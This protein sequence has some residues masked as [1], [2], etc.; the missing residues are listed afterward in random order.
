MK[1]I[2]GAVYLTGAAGDTFDLSAW[3]KGD[4]VPSGAFDIRA[5]FIPV[6]GSPSWVSLHFN[7]DSGDW[8]YLNDV[9]KAPI[10]Y[11]RIDIY[12]AYENNANSAYYDGIQLYKEEFG[13]SY[14]YDAKGNLTSN[15]DIAKNNSAFAYDGS[16]NLIGS[17]DPKGNSFA[18]EYDG[19]HNI[20]K[21]TSSEN[22][23]YNFTYDSYGNSKTSTIGDAVTYI[24]SSANYT[25]D[26]NYISSMTDSSG[27][28]V[29]YNYDS[30]KGTLSN[31]T[32]AN[33]KATSYGYD[34]MNRLTTASKTT[35]G[36]TITNSYSYNNDRISTIT[37]N[38][39]NYNFGYDSLGNN[40]TVAVGTQNLITNNYEAKTGKLLDSTYGNGQKVSSLY[41]GN[42]N[43]VGKVYGG[44]NT[45][46]ISYSGNIQDVGMT[47]VSGNDALLGTVGQNKR[48]ESLA[49]NLSNIPAGM[50]IKY[51][52]H[53]QNIG[54]QSWVYDGAMA[55][56]TG[57][58]LRMEAVCIK[59]EG[60]PAGYTVQYQAHV[61]SIGW[62]DPVQDGQ[63]AGTMGQS[64]RIEAIKI[65]LVKQRA[66]YKFDANTNLGY[67][68]DYVNG[69]NYNYSY[70]LSN[71]LTR[72]DESN[73]N[74]LAYGYDQN[75]NMNSVTEK[76]NGN[77]YTTSYAFDKDNKPTTTTYNRATAN[78]LTQS[79]DA[80]GRLSG[81]AMNT[82]VATYNTTFGYLAG[83]N[84]STTTK[85][86]S[87][88]NNGSAISYTYD[89]NGNISTITN[90]N[91]VIT[92][93]Y[94]ELNEIVRE[95]NQ[96]LNKTITTRSRV[97]LN[98]MYYNQFLDGI[99]PAYNATVPYINSVMRGL[100]TV[101]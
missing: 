49:V 37:H 45:Q 20:K 80:L 4:S 78:T 2:G 36:Q 96:V 48:L 88:T 63:I 3:A 8:Q 64:L 77:S 30:T 72:I 55:G 54:W 85:V 66:S 53:V 97:A 47:T 7:R 94:N 35:D 31:V 98:G 14:S 1:G 75:S 58:G 90:N 43:V 82:G 56:T 67:K 65:T 38:G 29:N 21:A 69:I 19:N 42:D 5:A 32:D 50:H 59:L 81:K 52:A 95:D 100:R 92:Y 61:Q 87:I 84:G 25:S 23:V 12:V 62:M 34:N 68:E 40:T 41:D 79:Y 44:D 9:I 73:G 13:D 26:G 70:D 27:N 89:N 11:A 15:S 28:T 83:A 17:T 51:Q 33:G 60:A 24:N 86:G 22:V 46:G 74:Y 91:Q 16:N 10:A 76:V 101:K 93:H 18:Y 99:G 39:F 6:S 71:R 57:Q